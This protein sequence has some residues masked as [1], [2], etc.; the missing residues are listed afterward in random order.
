MQ[1]TLDAGLGTYQI[2][3]YEVGAVKINNDLIQHS[4]VVMPEQLISPWEPTCLNELKSQHLEMLLIYKPSIILLGTGEK[5][6]FPLPAI[7]HI[8]TQHN[9][10]LE[11][12]D[13]RAACRTYNVLS[14]EG[15]AV[16]AA[17]LIR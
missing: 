11:I 3:A 7:T 17:L 12:M 10:G 4:V 5:L 8:I 2:R 9:I 1:F 14:A 15:R 13:T 16:A 6:V